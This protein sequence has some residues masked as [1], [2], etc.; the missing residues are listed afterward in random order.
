M[1]F[2]S[3]QKVDERSSAAP[4]DGTKRIVITARRRRSPDDADEARGLLFC[5]CDCPSFGR[6][7]ALAS[8]SRR[9][10][11]PAMYPVISRACPR[12]KRVRIQGRCEAAAE[13]WGARL[14]RLFLLSL[15]AL[16]CF[17]RVPDAP[18]CSVAA[19]ARRVALAVLLVGEEGAL[20]CALGQAPHR[21]DERRETRCEKGEIIIARDWRKSRRCRRLLPPSFRSPR[22]PFLFPT[23]ANK[24]KLSHSG[25]NIRK[26]VKD[27]FILKKPSKIH[28]RSRARSA[29]E[30][31]AKGRHTGYGKRRG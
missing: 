28:S 18:R 19:P 15:L 24:K 11:P 22:P 6:F 30:A 4:G 5:P 23:S 17:D 13:V 9:K 29:A 7:R 10:L 1:T 27:G 12:G 25:Q 14:D 16:S 26:L 21:F 31:K 20:L 3:G 8:P 2:L